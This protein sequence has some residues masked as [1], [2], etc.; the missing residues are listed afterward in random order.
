MMDSCWTVITTT[1]EGG[2]GSTTAPDTKNTVGRVSL[3]R[4]ALSCKIP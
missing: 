3:Q 1:G 2:E 4:T